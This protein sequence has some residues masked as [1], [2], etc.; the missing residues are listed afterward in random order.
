M[1][2]EDRVVKDQRVKVEVLTLDPSLEHMKAVIE[3]RLNFATK[4]LGFQKGDF[5]QLTN[6][7]YQAIGD[8]TKCSS[9]LALK[10]VAMLL[11]S[12]E[13]LATSR[14]YVITDEKVRDLGLTY[15]SL[16]EYWDSHLR[17]ATVLDLIR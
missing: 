15:E 9:G 1:S 13:I 8:L 14:P 7:A 3:A 12:E 4:L 5:I 16:C 17:Y 10:V 2:L 6:S 11:P